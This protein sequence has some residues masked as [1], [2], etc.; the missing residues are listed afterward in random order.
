MRR[1]PR[2]EASAPGRPAAGAVTSVKLASASRGEVS[3]VAFDAQ[4]A[5]DPLWVD[6]PIDGG[7]TVLVVSYEPPDDDLGAN[8][9]SILVE[10]SEDA[11]TARREEFGAGCAVA[12]DGALIPPGLIVATSI[13]LISAGGGRAIRFLQRLGSS[14]RSKR[15]RTPGVPAGVSPTVVGQGPRKGIGYSPA[16]DPGSASA[17][18]GPLDGCR[19]ELLGRIATAPLREVDSDGGELITLLVAYDPPGADPGPGFIQVE[20]SEARLDGEVPDLRAG[21]A[22]HFGG[23]LAFPPGVVKATFIRPVYFEEER[24]N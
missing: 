14:C 17:H 4:I 24:R 6:D 20:A 15:S 12:V 1:R 5:N 8:P 9:G 22:I 13:R 3:G 18:L 23:Q 16:T 21:K 2:S 11:T 7:R 10:V 19:V